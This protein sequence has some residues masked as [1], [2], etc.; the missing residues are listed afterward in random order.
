[1]EEGNIQ[2][3]FDADFRKKHFLRLMDF[4]FVHLK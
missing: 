3:M 1:M 2:N 4:L